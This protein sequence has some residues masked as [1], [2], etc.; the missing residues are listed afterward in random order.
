MPSLLVPLF[1][2]R[3]RSRPNLLAQETG[4]REFS[5][6]GEDTLVMFP[7]QAAFV[8]ANARRHRVERRTKV[9]LDTSP[10]GVVV[11]NAVTGP[12]VLQRG[13]LEDCR[14]LA[15]S[16]PISGGSP[17][18]CDLQAG[19]VPGYGKPP[20]ENSP[21]LHQR[22]RLQENGCR[23]DVDPALVR[24]F[25]DIIGDQADNM[26]ALVS[27]LLDVARIE[28]GTLPLG[29]EPTGVVVLRT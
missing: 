19:R 11:F 16:R 7:S 28:T 2:T 3:G 4:G 23:S 20:A 1:V 8:I 29:P 5:R 17:R 25:F 18:H 12:E 10:V 13:G 9:K 22:P 21:D 26:N 27:D 14:Q 24:Q 6:E 15:R